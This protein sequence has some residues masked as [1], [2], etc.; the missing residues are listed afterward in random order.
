MQKNNFIP[1]MSHMDREI[2][3]D[4]NRFAH[5]RLKV[6]DPFESFF[7]INMQDLT[8]PALDE[9]K[10]VMQMVYEEVNNAL[11][12][13]GIEKSPVADMVFSTAIINTFQMSFLEPIAKAVKDK[14]CVLHISIE[15]VWEGWED[16]DVE[17]IPLLNFSV[18]YT[19]GDKSFYC[20]ETS[21]N[22]SNITQQNE[23]EE[24]CEDDQDD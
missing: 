19:S 1:N 4:A 12:S 7:T 14:P 2:I 5:S 8:Q 17:K 20:C 21:L 11:E 13:T 6:D 15:V 9:A 18:M 24:D 3:H 23:T 22:L 10:R 16:A